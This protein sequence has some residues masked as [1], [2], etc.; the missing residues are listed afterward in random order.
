VSSVVFRV[1]EGEQSVSVGDAV[2]LRSRLTERNLAEHELRALIGD[3]V[4]QAEAGEDGVVVVT[5]DQRPAL[6]VALAA[7]KA[8]RGL[9][10]ELR[11]LEELAAAQ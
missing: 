6:I 7:E 8:D 11:A 3:A 10:A 5:D 9:T 4:R 2:G 1:R